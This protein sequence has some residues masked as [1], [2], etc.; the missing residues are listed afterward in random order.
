MY[1]YR[2]RLVLF[3]LAALAPFLGASSAFA[4]GTPASAPRVILTGYDTVA[5]FT[6]GKPVKGDPKLSS[7]W[8]GSRYYFSSNAHRELFVADPERYAPQFGG[9]CTGSLAKGIHRVANPEAWIIVE[10]KLYV[11]AAPDSQAASRSREMALKDPAGTVA[12]IAE[13]N[14]NWREKQ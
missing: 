12:K 6:D 9:H 11:F 5:Y 3:F 13:A 4:E 8:D 1:L 2:A 14:R 7:D 10:G